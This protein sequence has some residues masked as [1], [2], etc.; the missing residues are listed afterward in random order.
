MGKYWQT[1]NK[2]DYYFL[3]QFVDL[4]KSLR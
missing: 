1:E 4:L 3:P 2:Y